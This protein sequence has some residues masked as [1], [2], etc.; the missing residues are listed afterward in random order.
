ML[1][2]C[3]HDLAREIANDTGDIHALP[4]V[5]VRCPNNNKTF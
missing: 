4:L 3:I 2:T 5:G 1:E